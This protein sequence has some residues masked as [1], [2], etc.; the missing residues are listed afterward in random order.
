[1]S[2]SFWGKDP[3][4][5]PFF[6]EQFGNHVG[7]RKEITIEEL[8]N[9][10]ENPVPNTELAVTKIPAHK[11]HES[12]N[13]SFKRVAYGGV[14][15]VYYSSSIGKRTGNDGVV[16]LEI[17]EEDKT[18]G[19]SFHTISKGIHEK[20]HTLTKTRDTNGKEDSLQILHNLNEDELNGFEE[21]WK[22][23][24]DKH[25]P[26]WNDGFKSLEN[27]GWNDEGGWDRWRLPWTDG[28]MVTAGEPGSGSSSTRVKKITP[29][30]II[31]VEASWSSCSIEQA[32]E[33]C[34]QQEST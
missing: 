4:H 25:M 3:F 27:A 32:C 9:D 19:Q 2:K 15:G 33:S 5:D 24:A 34:S 1:M 8:N 18:V 21:N 13:F 11:S 14:N 16:L 30:E 10:G 12:N 23:K 31:R 6:T 20:G 22:V 29:V 26:G 28:A 17:K 7:S